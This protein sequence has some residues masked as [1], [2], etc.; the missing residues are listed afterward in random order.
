MEDL[1][2]IRAVILRLHVYLNVYQIWPQM[3]C[4]LCL[5]K[6]VHK[7]KPSGERAC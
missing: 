3:F 7:L 4:S 6:T 5:L 2:S 1:V